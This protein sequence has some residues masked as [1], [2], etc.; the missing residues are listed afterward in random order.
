MSATSFQISDLRD[1]SRV[2]TFDG[3]DG[4]QAIIVFGNIAGCA[5]TVTALYSLTELTSM[6]D[7]TELNIYVFDI[8]EGNSTQTIISQVGKVSSQIIINS[9]SSN[10]DYKKLFGMCFSATVKSGSLAMPLIVYKGAD[11]KIYEFTTGMTELD[12]IKKHVSAGGLEVGDVSPNQILNVTGKAVYDEAYKVLDLVNQE[13]AKEGLNPLVM[14]EELLEAAMLRA[15]E[16]SLYYRHDRPDG[17]ECITASTKMSGENI[18]MLQTSADTVMTSWMNSEGHRAN[19]LRASYQSIGI[20]CFYFNGM[21]AWTQC[22]GTG[23]GITGEKKQDQTV[24]YAIKAA[25]YVVHPELMETSGTLQVGETKQLQ[26]TAVQDA[27]SWCRTDINADSYQWESDSVTA[28]VSSDGVITAKKAGTAV[29]TGRN[30]GDPSA[31]VVYKLTILDKSALA[32][33]DANGD[34]SVNSL[35]AVMI[36]RYLAGYEGLKIDLAAADVNADGR[37][38]SLDA[39]KVLQKLA[40]YDVVLGEK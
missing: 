28:V 10:D 4:K 14:D 37:V 33:G 2:S 21:Y 27:Y 20:G 26:M 13:R 7:M 29:I 3:A 22:F 19:I 15:A 40:G 38:N 8:M 11:G 36:K 25:S 5:N 30:I 1:A 39:V 18:A 17:T 32:Y 34:S 31:T 23:A 24:T 9:I 16:C 6:V 35:D 12:T